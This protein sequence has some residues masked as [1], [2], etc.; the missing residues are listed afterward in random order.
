[1]LVAATDTTA[2]DYPGDNRRRCYQSSQAGPRVTKLGGAALG[3]VVGRA[4]PRWAVV[5]RGRRRQAFPMRALVASAEVV[6]GCPTGVAHARLCD[7]AM[8]GQV[9]P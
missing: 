8:S 7:P 2:A 3:C 4:R 6:G 9:L 5:G 1:M